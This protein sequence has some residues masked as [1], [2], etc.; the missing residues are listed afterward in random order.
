M[1]MN[2]LPGATGLFGILGTG[3]AGIAAGFL[4]LRKYLS[5]DSVERAGDAAQ[6]QIIQMLQDQVKQ[7]R[8]RADAASDARDRAVEQI[9]QLRAQ[10]AELSLRVENLKTQMTQAGVVS[11]A[12]SK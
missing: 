10:V 5:S 12:V 11:A 7:E 9:S 2:D 8:A 3:V 1:L 4:L 6:L